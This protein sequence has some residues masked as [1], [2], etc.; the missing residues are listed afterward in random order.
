MFPFSCA[1]MYQQRRGSAATFQQPRRLAFTESSVREWREMSF[2]S[3]LN[4]IKPSYILAVI[5]LKTRRP[6]V[7]GGRYAAA[8]SLDSAT[9]KLTMGRPGYHGPHGLEAFAL[10]VLVADESQPE[11]ARLRRDLG[12]EI[13][14]AEVADGIR[15]A[16]LAVTYLEVIELAVRTVFDLELVP[17]VELQQHTFLS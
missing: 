4:Q 12:R 6:A 2:R 8:K 7:K 1:A 5:S 16:V 3:N 14:A 17:K 10:D 9:S 13:R 15:E 11:V